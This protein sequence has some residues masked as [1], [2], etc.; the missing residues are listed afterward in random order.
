MAPA[1]EFVKV[2]ND[3]NPTDP[4]QKNH[5][6]S[7]ALSC[8]AARRGVPMQKTDRALWGH[9]LAGQA[10]GFVSGAVGAAGAA[11]AAG[12]GAAGRGAG[13]GSGVVRVKVSL[14]RVV[15]GVV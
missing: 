12:L 6:Q 9:G 11:G 5:H 14:R 4:A 8:S 2:Q 13:L 10:S 7:G 15:S 3:Q 1:R